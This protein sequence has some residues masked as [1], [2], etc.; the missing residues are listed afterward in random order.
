MA[1]PANLVVNILGS[2]KGLNKALKDAG[3]KTK[4]FAKG[5]KVAA[6]GAA[7]ALGALGGILITSIQAA[8]AEEQAQAKLASSILRV[9]GSTKAT[10]AAV[11]KWID[12]IKIGST[13]SDDELRPALGRLVDSTNNVKRAQSLLKVAMDLSV[14]SGKPLDTVTS[15]LSKAYNGNK[16]ALLKLFPEL[17]KVNDKTKT[18]RDLIDALGKKY[19]TA[20]E[21][22]SNTAAGGLQDLQDVFNDLQET[23]GTQ[24]LPYLKDF[25][26]WAKSKEG[27]QTIDNLTKVV[28]GL[29]DAFIKVVGGIDEVII[30]FQSIRAFFKSKEYSQLLDVI[31]F[32]NPVLYQALKGT[33]PS[34]PRP[35]ADL[36]NDVVNG[37]GPSGRANNTRNRPAQNGGAV[38][39]TDVGA[40]RPVTVIVQTIDPAAAG[41][42]V[43]QAL[44]TDAVRTGRS[45]VPQGRTAVRTGFYRN[46][47][48]V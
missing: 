40:G 48:V 29:A 39:T 41:R 3:K 44:N 2:A 36:L 11:E 33:R 28:E 4:G 23:I 47:G 13:F 9:K 16:T 17:V 7:A 46:G 22:A 43:R 27:K 38:A 1:G 8:I 30:G 32:V 42:A 31:K 20:D 14:A 12:T 19:K 6:A 35:L 15:A 21:N 37:P 26:K 5:V 10:T 45:Q 34:N 24:F 25:T 18:G